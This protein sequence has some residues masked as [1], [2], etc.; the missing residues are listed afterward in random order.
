MRAGRF[1]ALSLRWKENRTNEATLR[2]VSCGH[3][4]HADANAA[5]NILRAGHARSACSE[6]PVSESAA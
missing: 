2:C 4:D 3:E 1:A 5:K 6:D